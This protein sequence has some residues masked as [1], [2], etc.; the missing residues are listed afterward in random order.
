MESRDCVEE[1]DRLELGLLEHDEN[2]EPILYTAS[3]EE[4]EEVF[5]KYQTARWAM[6]SLLLILAWGIGLLMLLYLPVRR[7]ICRKDVRS[8]KLYL[9]DNAIVYKVIPLS[10]LLFVCWISFMHFET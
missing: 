5:V 4:S 1:I 10:D 7:Y 3:F 6:Y 2:D 9:T 8:R